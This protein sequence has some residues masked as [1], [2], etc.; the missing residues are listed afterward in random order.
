MIGGN[1][2]TRVRPAAAFAGNF[3]GNFALLA[4][5]SGPAA[6]ADSSAWDGGPRAAV[7]LI[8]GESSREAAAKETKMVRAGVEIRLGPGWKTYWR[9]PGDSGV[10]PRFGFERSDNVATVAVL[11]PAPHG[12]SDDGGRSI[13]YKD[14]VILPLHVVPREPGKPVV[15]RLDL[16]YAICEKLCVP[17]EAKVELA[18]ATGTPTQERGQEL[19]LAA[20]EARVPRVVALGEGDKLAIRAIRREDAGDR[21]RLIVDVAA[22]AGA[23]I[24]LFAEGPT[25]DW[26]LPLPAPVAGA[27]TGLQRFA[28]EIDGVPPGASAKGAV[29]RL[30][31]VSG[32]A[33]IE[34][35]TR[36]D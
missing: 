24:E 20:S 33:A 26:A 15:L 36:L 25:A 7:R 5:L 19:A 11:F 6:A 9:Y 23:E 13:G 18:L 10:P 12:F 32:E 21:P 14:R 29:L 34:V 22:P 17:A 8:A 1:L 3:V 27:P 2:S 28:F 31:A 4:A 35:A 16:D 30:T